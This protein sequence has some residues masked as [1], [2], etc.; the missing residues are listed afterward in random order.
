MP[1]CCC[2][3]LALVMIMTLVCGVSPALLTTRRDLVASLRGGTADRSSTSRIRASLA[4][5]QLGLSLVLLVIAGLFMKSLINVS[6]V[7]LGMNIAGVTTFRLSPELNGLSPQRSRAYFERVA[8]A[9]R[10]LPGITSVTTATIRVQSG[11]RGGTNVTVEGFTPEPGGNTASDAADIGPNYFR[12]F[13]IPLLAGRDFTDADVLGAPRVAIVNQAFARKFKLGE[14]VV[15]KRMRPGAGRRPPDIEIVGLVADARYSQAKDPI[16]P[17]FFLPEY[18]NPRLGA[19]NFYIRSEQ[20]PE[21]VVPAIRD[22][23]QKIDA[24]IPIE[25]LRTVSTQA[26]D[27]VTLDRLVTTLAI[28]SGVV[29]SLLA[30]I[31]L[32]GVLA[33]NLAQRSREFGVRIALGA[34][35]YRIWGVVFGYVGR[36]AL[37]G[38]LSGI[39]AAFAAG[40]LAAAQFFEVP[41]YDVGVTVAAVAALAFVAAAAG[42]IPAWR[43]SRIKPMESLRSE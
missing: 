24:T 9:V 14:T 23:V 32:Y 3:P 39:I 22:T 34:N 8:E 15:G 31:G 10:R 18:Q 36:I 40:R 29:A 13:R 33:Y 5:A 28:G 7:E 19:L 16:Q 38:L 27:V 21:R 30:A 17:Q 1:A 12:T 2:L 11:S 6:R 42:S 25:N 41:G 20:P 4:S 43:A 35:V 37:A 26:G